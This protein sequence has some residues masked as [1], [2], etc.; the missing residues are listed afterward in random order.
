MLHFPA[1]D[2]LGLPEGKKSMSLEIKGMAD[3]ENKKNKVGPGEPVINGIM[4]PLKK[5]PVITSV[6]AIYVRP[7]YRGPIT[8]FIT[9]RGAH[10]AGILLKLTV[11]SPEK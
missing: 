2:M 11:Y 10:L 5:G 4:T 3:S 1:N 9:G 6:T 7:I 8:T